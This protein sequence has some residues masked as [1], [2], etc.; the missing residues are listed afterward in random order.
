[1]A[2][3]RNLRIYHNYLGPGLPGI[4]GQAPQPYSL[5]VEHRTRNEHLLVEN[6]AI[7]PIGETIKPVNDVINEA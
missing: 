1:M 6:Y 7:V 5:I 4:G 3:G 2:L